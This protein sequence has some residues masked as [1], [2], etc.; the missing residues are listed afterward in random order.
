VSLLLLGAI[1]TILLWVAAERDQNDRDQAFIDSHV[2]PLREPP[3]GVGRRL[4]QIVFGLL[5]FADLCLLGWIA[6]GH[7]WLAPG[8]LIPG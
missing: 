6:L 1:L 3:S 8:F 5:L 4:M 7:G 2:P